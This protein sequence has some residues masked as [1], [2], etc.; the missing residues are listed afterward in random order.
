MRDRHYL[1]LMRRARRGYTAQTIQESTMVLMLAILLSVARPVDAVTVKLSSCGQTVSAG[2]SA[3]LMRDLDCSPMS[4]E[5]GVIL[6]D[7]A[8][9]NMNGFTVRGMGD[10]FG[11]LCGASSGGRASCRVNG[12]GSIEGFS[13][14]IGGDR[15]RIVARGV[16]LE[17]NGYG[18]YAPNACDVKVAS[19]NVL[20]SSFDGIS[21][22]RVRLRS[23]WIAYNGR[24]GVVAKRIVARGLTATHNGEQGVLQS[25]LGRRFGR[26]SHSSV[27]GNDGGYPSGVDIVGAGRLK[28]RQVRCRR[29]ERVRFVEEA[30]DADGGNQG[31]VVVG[32]FGCGDD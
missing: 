11:I 32:S 25:P 2:E 28:L 18:V 12:P 4:A 10:G 13:V 3:T 1:R 15:C 22:S 23:S 6:Q 8:T 21:G 30:G 24:H 9:V 16:L 26:I 14:G 27:I 29:S 19:I 17:G 7:G 5:G 20:N 31:T